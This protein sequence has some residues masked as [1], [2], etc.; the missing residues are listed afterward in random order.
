MVA[1]RSGQR[2]PWDGTVL[3]AFPALDRDVEVDVCV[4]GAGIAGLSTAYALAREGRSVIVLEDGTLGGG[5]TARTSAHL[6]NAVDDRYAEI[7]QLLGKE[8]ATLT[9]DSH[10]AAIDRIE[11]VVTEER[12]DCDS[13]GWTAISSSH[14]HRRRISS[15]S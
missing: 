13:C 6:S 8:A 11:R 12:I 10:S 2:S 7:E 9:A 15:P 14:P 5:Q 3:P 4:I 1:P